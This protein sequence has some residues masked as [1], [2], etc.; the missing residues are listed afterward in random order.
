MIAIFYSIS[1]GI[2]YKLGTFVYIAATEIIVEEF[3]VSKQ[4]WS[5]LF[6]YL[7]GFVL[8]SILKLY[9]NDS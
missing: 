8:M 3:S 2:L 1:S 4:K 6:I 5:K 9:E 7:I